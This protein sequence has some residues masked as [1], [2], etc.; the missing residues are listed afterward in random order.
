MEG[1]F[2]AKCPACLHLKHRPDWGALTTATVT[3]G[4]LL[5]SEGSEAGPV[6]PLEEGLG[7]GHLEVWWS[8]WQ[9]S[10]GGRGD[11]TNLELFALDFFGHMACR[12]SEEPHSRHLPKLDC[13]LKKRL[14]RS[15]MCPCVKAG[16]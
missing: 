9:R 2:T 1:Q 5:C 8:S 3:V 6:V 4:W 14:M 13:G 11:R 7:R 15:R 12:C 16:Y 10:Q